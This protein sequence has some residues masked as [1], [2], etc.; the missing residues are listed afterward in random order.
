[1]TY[2][3]TR[4]YDSLVAM[5][6]NIHATKL[7]NTSCFKYEEKEEIKQDLWLF[8]LEK[9]YWRR[10]ELSKECLFIALKRQA[11]HLLRSRLRQLQSGLFF[12]ESLNSM[13]DDIGFE[14]PAKMTLEDID[15]KIQFEKMCKN[16]SKK[17]KNVLEA[18][19]AGYT[20]EEIVKNFSVSWSVFSR[21]AEKIKKSDFSW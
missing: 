10:D 15:Y 16:L 12:T 7:V 17:E 19:L 8:Y 9:L 5:Y 20:Q 4:E 6:I 14:P 21:I 11:N 13:F 2:Q 1:M 3:I 18:L